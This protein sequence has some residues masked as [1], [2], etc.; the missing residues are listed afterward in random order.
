M[1]YAI[2]WSDPLL[3]AQLVSAYHLTCYFTSWAQYWPGL[4]HFKPDNINPCV[5]TL[6][7]YS[8]AGMQKN[9]ITTV[10]WNDVTLPTFQW[11]ERQKQLAENSPGHGRL[12]LWNC[13]IGSTLALAGALL[14]ASISSLSW[15]R[16][17]DYIHVMT[18][19]LHSS[20]KGYTGENSPLYKHPTDTGSNI[21]LNVWTN[22]TKH[23]VISWV[24]PLAN[25][26][27]LQD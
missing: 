17:L 3:N 4:G 20:W 16:Y 1:L 15:C 21:Y 14:R 5:Y 12:E 10:E 24:G 7:I 2:D 25:L 27:P 8:F 22:I 26:L 23:W 19:D 9:E 13:P 11:P 18:Y 6:Q